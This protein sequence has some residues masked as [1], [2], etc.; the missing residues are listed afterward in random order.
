MNPIA[1]IEKVINEHGSSAILRERL[2][3]LKNQISVVEKKNDA[4][5]PDNA[6]LKSRKN[7]S[8]P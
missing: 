7:T 3:L 4:L 1:Y 5:K 6:I 2:D 8:V